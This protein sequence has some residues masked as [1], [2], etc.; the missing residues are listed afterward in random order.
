MKKIFIGAIAAVVVAMI[1]SGCEPNRV[2][3]SGPNYLMFSDTL[4]HYGVK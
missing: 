4:Y 1:F 3:Y 2:N